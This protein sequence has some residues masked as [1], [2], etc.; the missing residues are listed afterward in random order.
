MT[1]LEE[2]EGEPLLPV[3]LPAQRQPLNAEVLAAHTIDR[4]PVVPPW[5]RSRS[6]FRALVV[7]LGRYGAHASTFHLARSPLYLARLVTRAPAGA[8]AGRP[9]G[10]VVGARPGAATDP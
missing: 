2:F 8:V 4:R 6:E 1:A 10:G 5:L 9:R 3:D 7:W